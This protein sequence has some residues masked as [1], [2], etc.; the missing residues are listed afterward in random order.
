YIQNDPISDNE[1]VEID[2]IENDHM[3]S[4]K[5]SKST[6]GQFFHM[7]KCLRCIDLLDAMAKDYGD[8][9]RK[10]LRIIFTYKLKKCILPLGKAPPTQE[11]FTTFIGTQKL[12]FDF[13]QS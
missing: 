4:K 7:F 11:Q 10:I 1:N 6:S 2:A 8:C 13:Q 3:K 12:S 9:P 5:A